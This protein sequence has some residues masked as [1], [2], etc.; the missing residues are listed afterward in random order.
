M[1]NNPEIEQILEAAIKLARDKHHEYVLTEHVLL[2][3]VR[4]HPFRRV[5]ETFGT[6]VL[7]LDS[8]LDQ[9][10]DSLISLQTTK[11]DYQPKKTNA[12]E[13]CFNR[14]LTQVLF[15][16][17]RT[18]TTLD[19]YLAMMAESNSHAHYFLLKYGIKKQEFSETLDR[20]Q[21]LISEKKTII[22]FE[23]FIVFHGH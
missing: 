17:R 13:R 9:Y 11:T 10:L 1:Q 12:L 5:L 23:Q 16:G 3:M 18:V 21:R 20:L 22:N 2:S 7:A 4:F 6:E 8:D 15:T 19:L 14:A